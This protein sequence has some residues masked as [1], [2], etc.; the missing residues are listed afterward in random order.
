MSIG[1]VLGDQKQETIVFKGLLAS[2]QK[3]DI[4]VELYKYNYKI[5]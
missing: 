3:L 1:K 2:V 4:E 5:N